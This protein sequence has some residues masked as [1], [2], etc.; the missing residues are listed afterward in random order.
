MATLL[1]RSVVYASVGIGRIAS[2]SRVAVWAILTHTIVFRIIT[3]LV[4][5]AIVL[6]VLW[7]RSLAKWT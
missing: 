6:V 3:V 4:A 5:S 1:A 7:I 2:L